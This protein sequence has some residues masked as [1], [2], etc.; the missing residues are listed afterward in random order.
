MRDNIKLF[1]ESLASTLDLPEP[2]LEIG[3]LQVE[4]QED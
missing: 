2:V 3:S 1:V 4:E